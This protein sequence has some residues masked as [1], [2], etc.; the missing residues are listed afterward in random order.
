MLHLEAQ[1]Y[2]DREEFDPINGYARLTERDQKVRHVMLH[3]AKAAMKLVSRD[4][5]HVVHEVIPDISIYRSQI[6]NLLAEPV[7]KRVETILSSNY[8]I[9]LIGKDGCNVDFDENYQSFQNDV[10]TANGNLATYLERLEHG[11]PGDEGQLR[12]AALELDWASRG[13]A[14]LYEVDASQLHLARL[15]EHLGR[16]LPTEFKN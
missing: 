7:K 9:T 14:T 13:F 3:T 6:V 16:P 5:E 2:F 1:A 15:E 10:V 11:E 8:P 12:L 4:R